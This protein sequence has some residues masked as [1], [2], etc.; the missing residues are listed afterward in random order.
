MAPHRLMRRSAVPA[1]PLAHGFTELTSIADPPI[2]QKFQPSPRPH[3]AGKRSHRPDPIAQN[4]EATRITEPVVT[5]R[6]GPAG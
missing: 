3:K 1:H 4:R 2:R 5:A 6:N